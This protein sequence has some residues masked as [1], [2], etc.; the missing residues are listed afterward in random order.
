MDTAS[1]KAAYKVICLIGGKQSRH[2]LDADGIGA[3]LFN[4]LCVINIV[5]VCKYRAGGIE[6]ATCT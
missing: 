5:L 3:R 1:F 2:V 6:M 4:S